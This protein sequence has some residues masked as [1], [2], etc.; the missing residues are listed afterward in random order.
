[1]HAPTRASAGFSTNRSIMGSSTATILERMRSKYPHLPL[2]TKDQKA[3]LRAINNVV[4]EMRFTDSPGH[5]ERLLCGWI[6]NAATALRFLR[7]RP[8][9]VADDVS[10]IPELA[11]DRSCDGSTLKYHRLDERHLQE[12][13]LRMDLETQAGGDIS[14]YI[15]KHYDISIFMF[16]FEP[17]LGEPYTF[18]LALWAE[19]EDDLWRYSYARKDIKLA[20]AIA[21][22]SVGLQE[23]LRWLPGLFFCMFKS[24]E[25]YPA[26]RFHSQP[27]YSSRGIVRHLGHVELQTVTHKW[28]AAGKTSKGRLLCGWAINAKAAIHYLRNQLHA[29][30]IVPPDFRCLGKEYLDGITEV[31]YHAMDDKYVRDHR[32]DLHL[33]AIFD[34]VP[35]LEVM[36]GIELFEFDPHNNIHD[37]AFALW[38]KE[39][40]EQCRRFYSKRAGEGKVPLSQMI[41]EINE[42]FQEAGAKPLR[43]R[44][45]I[46]WPGYPCVWMTL[47]VASYAWRNTAEDPDRANGRCYGNQYDTC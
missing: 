2:L 24:K 29:V 19:E 17:K 42:G 43:W 20:E 28:S 41:S 5:D 30:G 15:R 34:I 9:A 25:E 10:W 12:D 3:Q 35:W 22:I 39:D 6:L 21:E 36:Y 23:P 40:D 13:E 38:A 4:P 31:N 33:Q 44:Y 32:S 45:G 37:I 18:G 16:T 1:M 11:G 7:T 47:T 26:N 8:D 27:E 14:K 46:L